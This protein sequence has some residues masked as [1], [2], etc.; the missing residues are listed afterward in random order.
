MY[1]LQTGEN[2]DI[3]TGSYTE[4]YNGSSNSRVNNIIGTVLGVIQVVGS[5]IAIIMLIYIGIMYMKESPAGKAE[6]KGRLLPYFI[7]AIL[8]FGGS[9]LMGVIAK[10]ANGL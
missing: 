7:G 2:G 10:W 5:F 9:N 4:I 8:L 3:N 6:T 1:V